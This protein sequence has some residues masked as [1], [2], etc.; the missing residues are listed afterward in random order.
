M[1]EVK[2]SLINSCYS[3]VP[4]KR[5][6]IK[7]IFLLLL[8][9]KRGKKRKAKHIPWR[10]AEIDVVTKTF[11]Q[12]IL[13]GNGKGLPGKKQCTD[14]I[15]GNDVLKRRSWQNVKDFVRNKQ[16]KFTPAVFK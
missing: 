11:K 5:G 10:K 1:V 3:R 9:L 14:I 2:S 8:G 13:G 6:V 4:N 15:N 12:Y 16:T 7:Y